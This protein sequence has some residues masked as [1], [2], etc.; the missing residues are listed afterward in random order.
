[1]VSKRTGR[2][3]GRPRKLRPPRRPRAGR[4][5]RVFLQDADRYAVALLD[6]MLAIELGPE[7]AC[8][9]AI[10][11]WEVGIEGNPPLVLPGQVSTNWERRRTKM[12]A[13]AATLEGRAATLRGKQ[14]CRP[15][16]PQDVIW[17][18]AMG[19]AFMLVL[20]A[21]DPETARPV[22]LQRAESVGEGEYARRKML[23]MLYAKFSPPEFPGNFISRRQAR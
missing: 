19:A 13:N 2:P 6:A 8:A 17:R 22:I 15:R 5:L 9:L 4:P 10:A 14:R 16:D 18:R 11:A 12:G 1:M 23:P 7:R 3:V 20:Q 21:R